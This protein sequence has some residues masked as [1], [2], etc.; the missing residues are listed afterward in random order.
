MTRE[1][2]CYTLRLKPNVNLFQN[3]KGKAALIIKEGV[4]KRNNYPPG[5]TFIEL[6]MAVAIVGLLAAIAIPQ[7][8][9]YRMRAHDSAAKSALNNLAKAQ[10]N[11][12]VE[13]Q[14]YTLNKV[15][16]TASSGYREDAKVNVNITNADTDSWTATAQ[17]IS[18]A[19]IFTYSSSG[20]GLQ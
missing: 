4:M 7:F 12:H 18:S 20:G 3:K 1:T 14:V 15:V 19:N 5:F 2:R 13:N 17:H 10:E 6:M 11:F 9:N 16:L 8:S